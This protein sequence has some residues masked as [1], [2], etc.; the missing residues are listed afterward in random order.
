MKIIGEKIILESIKYSDTQNIIKWRNN[1]NVRKNFIFQ[2]EFTKEIHENWM[3]NKVETGEVI[4]F[5][6]KLKIN[7]KPIG[8][9]YLRDIMN[10]NAEYGIFIGE[11]LERGNGCGSEAANL[12]IDYAF[13]KLGLDKIILRVFKDNIYAIRSYKK[14]GFVDSFEKEIVIQGEKKKLLFMEILSSEFLKNRKGE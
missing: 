11:D 7:N 13:S 4:Q 6:I 9:V 5:I 3:K 8:S 1:E 14:V 2:E 12:I 10:N